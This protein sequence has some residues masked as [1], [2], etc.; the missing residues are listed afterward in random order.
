MP[1]QPPLVLDGQLALDRL[2]GKLPLP[3]ED[4]LYDGP[5][6]LWRGEPG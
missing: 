3:P 4:L 2:D 5:W 6:T 1:E